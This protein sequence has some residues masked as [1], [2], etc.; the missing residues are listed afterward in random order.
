MAFQYTPYAAVLG[1][2]ALISAGVALAAWRRRQMSA[3]GPL[4]VGLMV[5]IAAYAAVAALESAAV[6]LPLK[7]VYSTLEYVGSGGVITFFLAFALRF[8]NRRF[9]LQHLLQLGMMPALNAALVATNGWHGLVW[10][11]FLP[12]PAGSN[13]VIYHHG[14]GFFWIMAWMYIYVGLGGLLLLQASLRPAKLYR[15][16]ARLV[17]LGALVPLVGSSIYMLGLSPPGLNLAPL[18]FMLTGVINFISLFRF[19]LLDL[20][21][22]ARDVLIENMGDGVLVLD[23][24]HRIVDINPTAQRFLGVTARVVGLPASQVLPHWQA[25]AQ[26]IQA[27]GIHPSEFVLGAFPHSYLEL[28]TTPL[29]SCRRNARCDRSHLSAAT[30][31]PITGHLL[32]L[33]DVTE[34]HRVEVELRQAND[35]LLQQLLENQALQEQLHRQAMQDGLTDI[36]NRR[37]FEE[38]LPLELAQAAQDG[39]PLVVI[40]LDIDFFKQIND[41]YGHHAGDKVLQTF[42]ELLLRHSRSGEIVCRYGGEEFALAL[43]GLDLEAGYARAEKIR[44][45]CETAWVEYSGHR[46]QTTV[47]GGIGVFPEDGTSRDD[48]LKTVDQAL[49]IA[50]VD[51]RNRICCL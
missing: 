45:A 15:Q 3:A 17:L 26:E 4:F 23:L 6:P 48:L 1:L 13:Q 30:P 47:S 38:R 35:Q 8:T 41:T 27:P 22:V 19:R 18:S 28:R 42:A 16:Q 25:I 32:V 50:K 24:K 20:I 49:Y 46:I 5:A 37:Y 21:P 44:L 7:L 2:T 10:T 31:H 34:R 36:S 12:G 33:R 40:L 29:C 9:T 39:Y 14:P 11:A 51:G 43:P